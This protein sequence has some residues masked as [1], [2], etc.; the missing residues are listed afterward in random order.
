MLEGKNCLQL[1]FSPLSALDL[2]DMAKL[3]FHLLVCTSSFLPLALVWLVWRRR[4]C[5]RTVEGAQAWKR[6]G[7]NPKLDSQDSEVGIRVSNGKRKVG[8]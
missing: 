8:A 6:D 7:K 5:S 1:E 3:S 2:V 4:L